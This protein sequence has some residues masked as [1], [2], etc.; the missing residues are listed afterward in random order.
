MGDVGGEESVESFDVIY[1]ATAAAFMGE[2]FG[3]VDVGK[4][5]LAT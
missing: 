2:E 1:V 4:D 5:A 3:A